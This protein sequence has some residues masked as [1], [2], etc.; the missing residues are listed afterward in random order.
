MLVRILWLGKDSGTLWPKQ[1]SI[2]CLILGLVKDTYTILYNPNVQYA[3]QDPMAG[4]GLA[5]PG[6]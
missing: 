2:L 4:E 3:L 1:Y 6:R 5:V